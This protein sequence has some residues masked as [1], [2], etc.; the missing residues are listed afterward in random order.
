[1]RPNIQSIQFCTFW[2]F[3]LYFFHCES[4]ILAFWSAETSQLKQ[5]PCSAAVPGEPSSLTI[6][7]NLSE[8]PSRRRR[9]SRDGRYI[10]RSLSRWVRS[11]HR[12]DKPEPSGASAGP[13]EF[14]CLPRREPPRAHILLLSAIDSSAWAGRET[15]EDILSARRPPPISMLQGGAIFVPCL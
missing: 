10:K 5:P 11:D 13:R 6:R 4:R 2:D 12:C 8:S 3:Q 7:F 15:T 9:F 1:M 14:H